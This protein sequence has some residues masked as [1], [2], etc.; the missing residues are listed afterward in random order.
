VGVN[1]NN[2][3]TFINLMSA[4]VHNSANQVGYGAYFNNTGSEV[5][6]VLQ[7]LPIA[8]SAFGSDFPD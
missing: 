8:E 5:N 1:D 2:F 4:V 6:D 7:N 3:A